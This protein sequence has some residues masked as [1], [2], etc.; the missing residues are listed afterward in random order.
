MLN[1][2]CRPRASFLR[3]RVM[4]TAASLSGLFL[5][6][7]PVAHAAETMTMPLAPTPPGGRAL[8]PSPAPLNQYRKWQDV[9]VQDWTAANDRVGE[10]GGWQTYL[11][12]AQAPGSA[13]DAGGHGH[14][15]Q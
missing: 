1:S 13:P 10:I 4:R 14:H 11:R 12:D 6:I 15:G 3:M 7:L 2:F 8:V 9:P 5:L